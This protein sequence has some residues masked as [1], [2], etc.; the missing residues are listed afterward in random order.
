MQIW[1][2][3]CQQSTWY[4]GHVEGHIKYDPSANQIAGVYPFEHKRKI[5]VSWEGRSPF[6]NFQRSQ[7]NERS[8]QWTFEGRRSPHFLQTEYD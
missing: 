6:S 7:D 8:Y 2:L 1:V 4:S 3:Q 5:G